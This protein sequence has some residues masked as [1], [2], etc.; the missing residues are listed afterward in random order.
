MMVMEG[1]AKMN[2]D[3]ELGTELIPPPDHLDQ[4]LERGKRS[5]DDGVA[6]DDTMFKLTEVASQTIAA[7]QAE[8]GDSWT[9][10]LVIELPQI[11]ATDFWSDL[12][13]EL[14]GLDPEYGGFGATR[15]FTWWV[16][17]SSDRT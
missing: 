15:S 1:D 3:D 10:E 12:K 7:D 9:F 6:I 2:L 16:V 11:D 13:I 5:A 17:P 8:F 4:S 14:F